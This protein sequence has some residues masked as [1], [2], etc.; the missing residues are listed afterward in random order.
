MNTDAF[1]MRL[2][3][4]FPGERRWKE[5]TLCA[6]LLDRELRETLGS[7]KLPEP[8]RSHWS[9]PPRARGNLPDAGPNAPQLIR[10]V[11][12]PYA[13]A[14]VRAKRVEY[15]SPR[16]AAPSREPTP[17]PMRVAIDDLPKITGRGPLRDRVLPM[18]FRQAWRSEQS[19]GSP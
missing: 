19:E 7:V 14:T 6:S 5:A 8:H 10:L 2:S 3:R 18:V 16:Q 1:T 9:A 13:L 4:T 12:H 15:R 17:S 11:R